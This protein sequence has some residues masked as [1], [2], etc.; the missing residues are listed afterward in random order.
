MVL[1]AKDE[2]IEFLV[3]N[4]LSLYPENPAHLSSSSISIRYSEFLAQVGVMMAAVPA[5]SCIPVSCV[6][7]LAHKIQDP[8]H[9]GIVIKCLPGALS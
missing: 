5:P 2:N 4:V 6:Q 9:S 8:E 7:P 1:A 3:Q